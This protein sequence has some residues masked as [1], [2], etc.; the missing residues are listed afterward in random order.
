MGKTF[1][2][3]SQAIRY[4]VE[5]DIR[6]LKKLKTYYNLEVLSNSGNIHIIYKLGCVNHSG[7][8]FHIAVRTFREPEYSVSLKDVAQGD[9][10]FCAQ[11]YA[12][13]Y[14]AHEDNRLVPK[15]AIGVS[16]PA[17]PEILEYKLLLVEDLTYGGSRKI[18]KEIQP[19]AVLINGLIYHVDFDLMS[20]SLEHDA[21]E[22]AKN[23]I[24]FSKTNVINL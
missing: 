18:E 9:L 13:I 16:F 21:K 12:R 2:E 19:D 5:R 11:Q 3:Q 15:F 6:L 10:E 1:L 24:F 8:D 23:P 14:D 20:L 4:A 17:I 7:E 22:Y